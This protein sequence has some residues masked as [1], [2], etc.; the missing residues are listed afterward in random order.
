MSILAFLA[1]MIIGVGATLAIF[2]YGDDEEFHDE[3][4]D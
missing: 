1:G 2:A 3:D 4:R